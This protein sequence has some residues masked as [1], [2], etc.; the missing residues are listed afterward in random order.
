MSLVKALQVESQGRRLSGFCTIFLW[1]CCGSDNS[2]VLATIRKKEVGPKGIHKLPGLP[3]WSIS[4]TLVRLNLLSTFL[5]IVTTVLLS[6]SSSECYIMYTRFTLL[7]VRHE[8]LEQ[9]RWII[10]NIKNC[11]FITL[12]GILAVLLRRQDNITKFNNVHRADLSF[13]SLK[14]NDKVNA[15]GL[16]FFKWKSRDNQN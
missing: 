9:Y 12:F 15:A 4:E 3:S 13:T 10:F 7:Y 1:G 16:I 2:P 5:L 14:I 11:R 6:I 8:M